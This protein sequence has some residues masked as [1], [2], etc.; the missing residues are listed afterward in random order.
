MSDTTKPVSMQWIFNKTQHP[1]WSRDLLEKFKDLQLVKKSP[2]FCGTRRRYTLLP[3]HLTAHF[4]LPFIQRITFLQFQKLQEHSL[5]Q[6]IARRVSRSVLPVPQATT[7]LRN[8][9]RKERSTPIS[10]D[11]HHM[12]LTSPASHPLQKCTKL[13]VLIQ[14]LIGRSNRIACFLARLCMV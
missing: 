9:A 13:P 8:K 7:L 4:R 6:Y 1:P 12:A 11:C 14:K 3:L 2:A 10:C 5:Q